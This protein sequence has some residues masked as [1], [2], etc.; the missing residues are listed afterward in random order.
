MQITFNNQDVSNIF[1]SYP[2]HIKQKLLVVRKLIYDVAQNNQ[3]EVG[4]I[5]ETLKWGEPSYVTTQTK[6][7]STIRLG[8]RKS[9]PTEYAIYFNCH[10]TLVDTFKIKYGNLFT[11]GG[12][13]SIIFSE[14]T[15][16]P[17]AELS[18]CILIALTYH[19]RKAN[20][21]IF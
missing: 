15:N 8:W 5:E 18:D 3:Q 9:H 10:T 7:G 4:A 21:I 16:V 20:R 14:D 12:N 1:D 13:R 11:Y 17:I 6:S 19:S 2:S